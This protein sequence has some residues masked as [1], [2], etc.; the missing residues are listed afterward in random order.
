LP[1]ELAAHKVEPFV[2]AIYQHEQRDG[3]NEGATS[4]SALTLN[5]YSASGTRFLAGLSGGSLSQDPLAQTLTY[6]LS[7]AVGTDTGSL[8]RTSVGSELAGQALT[9]Q[10]PH[11]GREFGQLSLGGTVRVAKQGYLF[12]GAD[13]E[14]AARRTS[15]GITGGVR[16]GF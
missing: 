6:K 2:R 13:T 5:D 11:S 14:I 16:V 4:I 10:S 8:I 12:V 15:Y 3:A 9:I 7:A 1:I